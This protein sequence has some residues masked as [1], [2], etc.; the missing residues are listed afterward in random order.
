MG[1]SGQPVIDTREWTVTAGRYNSVI[2]KTTIAGTSRL[3]EIVR[4]TLGTNENSVPAV[5][6]PG[7]EKL[8]MTV[9]RSQAIRPLEF[10]G[11]PW[12]RDWQSHQDGPREMSKHTHPSHGYRTRHARAG[13]SAEARER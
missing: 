10:C 5:S 2:G 11:R 6:E 9:A 1:D 13:K 7:V 4:L 3:V 8:T 12:L